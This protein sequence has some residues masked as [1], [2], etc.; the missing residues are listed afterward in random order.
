M[1]SR[2]NGGLSDAR[3]AKA[4][5]AAQGRVKGV[6]ADFTFR[7][8]ATLVVDLRTRTVRYCIVKDIASDERA[9]PRSG[10]PV[11]CRERGA[12]CHYSGLR[13]APSLRIPAPDALRRPPWPHGS[14]RRRNFQGPRPHSRGRRRSSRT[15]QSVTPSSS[16]GWVTVRMYRDILGDCFLLRFPPETRPST[17]SSIA[18]FCRDA[19]RQGKGAPHHGECP[20][21][22]IPPRRSGRN[23]HEHVDHLSGFAQAREFFDKIEVDEL[24]LAWTEDPRDDQAN[25]LR[26]GRTFRR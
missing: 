21:G 6:T 2:R 18:G 5:R 7:G 12:R 13:V 16:R 8:G 4:G 23:T 11:R 3:G 1:R 25:R 14:S 26:A 24:W 19:R 20:V 9:C 22:H 17:C 15:R 10:I